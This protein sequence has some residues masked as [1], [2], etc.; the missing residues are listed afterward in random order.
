MT[1]APRPEWLTELIAIVQRLCPETGGSTSAAAGRPEKFGRVTRDAE[2]GAGWFWTGLAGRSADSDRLGGGYLAPTEGAGQLRFQ[3]IESVQEG[4][5]LKVRVAEHAPPEG[6]FLWVPG[7]APGLLEKSLL[8]GLSRIDRF[9]LVNRFAEGR[10]DPVPPDP[11]TGLGTAGTLNAEQSRARAGC[12]SPGVHLVWGPPAT[13][14]TKVIALALQDIIASGKSALL[15]SA[16]NIAV[17]NA[18]AK[19]AAAVKRGPGVMVRAGTPHLREAAENPLSACRSWFTAGRKH[20]SSCAASW[21][22]R[23]RYV[24]ATLTWPGSPRCG[25]NL[26]TSTSTLIWPPKGGWPMRSY[27]PARRLS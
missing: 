11:G 9:D 8:A 13:G 7:R 2:A 3:L 12:R 21:K 19:A 14:K 17:D 5:V 27:E 23:S 16:T 15:V 1:S 26:R 10:T 24:K 4:N 6:L 20:S 25:P 22:N 18:L